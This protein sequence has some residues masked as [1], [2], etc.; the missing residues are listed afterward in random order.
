MSVLYYIGKRAMLLM[1]KEGED[2]EWI[3]DETLF[4]S[5]KWPVGGALVYLLVVALCKHFI[6]KPIDVPKQLISLH[7]L[8]LSIGSGIMFVGCL[9][10]AIEVLSP[11]PAVSYMGS[12]H[13][14][15]HCENHKIEHWKSRHALYR[16]IWQVCEHAASYTGFDHTINE[17]QT[18]SQT[19][20]T[21]VVLRA[22]QV[23][24]L[25]CIKSRSSMVLH[26]QYCTHNSELRCVEK[27]A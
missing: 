19:G 15:Q 24:V 21:S 17:T 25:G 11:Q 5:W 18:Y 1:F 4:S 23:C 20:H 8:V 12:L 2:F 10:S 13:T 7:N 16:L 9:S 14:S 3:R 26:T 27:T 6:A 22:M